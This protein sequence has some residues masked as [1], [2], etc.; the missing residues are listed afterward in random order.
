MARKT[1]GTGPSRSKKI[2]SSVPPVPSQGGAEMGDM[3]SAKET[4]KEVLES[5]SSK[6]SIPTSSIPVAIN[7]HSTNHHSITP[8]SSPFSSSV[9]GSFPQKD[10]S[11]VEVE[12]R[13]RAYELYLERRANGNGRTGD[14]HQDW[15][16]AEREVR[17]RTPSR[18]RKSA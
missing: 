2:S 16:D 3:V 17:S 13:Q 18:E 6:S 5:R 14:Q 11:D 7:E 12:I 4:P 15:L 9:Q 8:P 10:R 1:T